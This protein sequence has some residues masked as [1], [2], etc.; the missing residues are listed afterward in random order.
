MVLSSSDY[1]MG[2]KTEE[3]L[4]VLAG[5]SDWSPKYLEQPWGPPI[6]LIVGA[7]GS[8][9]ECKATAP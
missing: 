5:A 6:I 1:A 9:L 3:S 2:L 7:V 4:L 8:S